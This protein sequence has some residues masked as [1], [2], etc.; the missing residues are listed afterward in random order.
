MIVPDLVAGRHV[1]GHQASGVDVIAR[2]MAAVVVVAR[3]AE[4]QIDHPQLGVATHRRPDVRVAGVLP[5]LLLPGLKP[6]VERLWNRLEDP[7]QFSRARV[8]PPDVARRHLAD[9]GIVEDR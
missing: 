7:P 4:R 5:R 3:R 9:G 1:D 6:F 8:E 2:T